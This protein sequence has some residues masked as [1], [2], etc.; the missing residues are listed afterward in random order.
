MGC[1]VWGCQE[2]EGSL[3]P[4]Y[5]NRKEYLF[6]YSQRFHTVE[7][8]TFFYGVPDSSTLNTWKAQL[9]DQFRLCIKI[10]RS[11]SHQGDLAQKCEEALRFYEH[12]AASLREY[13]GPFFLLLPPKYDVSQGRDLS[14][15]LNFWRKN[16]GVPISVSTR[17]PSWFIDAHHA[18]LNRM[19]KRLGHGRVI[20]D[21]RP[22]Y[23][24]SSGAQV[25]CNNKKPDLPIHESCTTNYIFVRLICHP[26]VSENE[27]YFRWW[28]PKIAQWFS[29]ER[30]IYFF[31]HCPQEYHSPFLARRFQQL[32]EEAE[33][34]VAPLPWNSL[35]KWGLFD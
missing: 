4:S 11:I 22:I 29:E 25:G 27:P 7:G 2:W 32:L 8:N 17:H 13:L 3:Y 16:I 18:R 12:V 20:L 31:I 30:D 24:G 26:N 33:I 5:C 1:A 14:I 19:L 21:T 23:E 9:H 28:L 35:P 10:P 15:F 34:G 6:L